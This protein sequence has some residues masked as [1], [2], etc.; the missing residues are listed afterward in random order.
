M[1][2]DAAAA[3]VPSAVQQSVA[4]AASGQPA[5]SPLHGAPAFSDGD[6]SISPES[7]M[8]AKS[9][10][11]IL[12]GAEDAL[13]RSPATPAMPAQPV[14]STVSETMASASAAL[15]GALAST[16]PKPESTPSSGVP[17]FA[18]VAN[19]LT[20]RVDTPAE[21]PRFDLDFHLDDAERPAPLKRPEAAPQPSFATASA[22]ASSSTGALD[23]DKLDLSFDSTEHPPLED[24]TPSVLDGQWHDA[25]TKL[26]LAKAYQEMGDVDGA[27]EILQEVLHEGD[28]QQKSEANA[29]LAKLSA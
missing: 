10:A 22:T 25:A 1:F 12:A 24:Q 29:L 14:K 21:Q 7:S 8:P 27:R 15:A 16:K 26:D 13:A 19:E 11:D 5:R 2:Q 23:L 18:D 4:G 17:H 3:Q 28:D 9:P 6:I 20:T